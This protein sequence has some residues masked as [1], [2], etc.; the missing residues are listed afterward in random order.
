MLV[1]SAR[2]TSL[3]IDL[4]LDDTSD[5]GKKSLGRNIR[6]SYQRLFLMAKAY[7]LRGGNYQNDP[8]LL[9][10][11]V[12]G[13]TFLS[14][15]YYKAGVQEWG[16]WW[17]WELGITRDVHNLLTLVFDD[18]PKTLID[19][20]VQ[21]TR[22]FVP[23]ATH[24]G[25][26]KGAKSSTN[27]KYRISTGGNRT[28]NAQVVLIR[29][30][31][32]ENETEVK[33][34]IA[35]LSPVLQYVDKSD[36]FYRDGSFIQHYDIAYNGTYGNVL[37]NGLGL[38]LNLVAGSRWEPSGNQEIYPIIF[39][40]YEPLLYRGT[41][42]EFVNGRAISRNQEQG[43]DVGHKV[44][45]SLMHYIDGAPAQYKKRLQSL[46]KALVLGD[47]FKNF[48]AS[49]GNV[50]NY[51]KAVA[52]V[53]DSKIPERAELIGHFSF[54]SMDRA[55]HRRKGWAFSVAMHS[56]R[57]GNY[58]CMN[59][60]NRKGWYTGDG[61]TYLYN[62]QLDHY[63]DFWPV[64]DSTR[65]A[66]TTVVDVPIAECEGQRNEI[67]G[68]RKKNMDW[69]GTLRLGEY[70]V[71][72]MDFSNWNDTLSAR[73]SY[74]MFDDEVV[75]LGSSISAQGVSP[76]TVITNRKLAT[77]GTTKLSIDGQ[78]WQNGDTDGASTTLQA[79]ALSTFSIH[80]NVVAGSN[81]NYVFLAPASVV[82][83]REKR[84]GD[85]N[86]I[87]TKKGAVSAS[88]VSAEIEHKSDPNYAY[89][90]LPNAGITALAQYA[91]APQITVVQN[92]ANAHI[93]KDDGVALLAANV[94]DDGGNAM[95]NA[96]GNGITAFGK[97]SIM[98]QDGPNNMLTIAV[99]D[100]L[101][102]QQ[103]LAVGFTKPMKILDGPK[104]SEVT[105]TKFEIDVSALKG[106][107]YVFRE[108][109]ARFIDITMP[110]R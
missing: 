92:D 93:V 69:V 77:K 45:Q 103:K 66:G 53:N 63:T 88:F 48:F 7:R 50:V 101:Q 72:G 86:D 65:L 79:K 105:A 31:L 70:G 22:Y 1:G 20:H 40:S 97:M 38:Q 75:M 11:I 61:M 23:E 55:V 80:N 17:F 24:L 6:I 91:K 35:A 54:P 16:N 33:D 29:G 42:L 98:V 106:Q 36:G 62:G 73:K 18:V 78:H 89:A 32:S 9:A 84:T 21:V 60:E 34:A 12:D 81:V 10:A 13:M 56:S 100:P 82:L 52:L 28:D 99:S 74:F 83:K 95:G 8:K 59:K 57:V 27:P 4:V 87:G 51:Q 43:H 76:I 58:E 64:V 39:R 71:A 30:I 2:T 46:F 19:A 107:S 5:A 49:T 109:M 25:A 102:N 108:I 85:W 104:V 14:T 68:D 90:L 110:S 96:L 15:K 37:L 94:W 26:G 41:M 67:R 47:T 44:M 3:W